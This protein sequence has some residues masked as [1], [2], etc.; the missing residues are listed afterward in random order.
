M[1][2]DYQ[3]V[4]NDDGIPDC[5]IVINLNTKKLIDKNFKKIEKDGR[6]MIFSMDENKKLVR[7]AQL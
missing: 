3:I 7:I 4:R 2:S 5:G 6:L 1:P